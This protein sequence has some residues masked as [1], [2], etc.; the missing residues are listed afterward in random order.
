MIKIIGNTTAT[1]IVPPN[2]DSPYIPKKCNNIDYSTYVYSPC[3]QSWDSAGVIKTGTTIVKKS[4]TEFSI[5][6][7][8]FYG[9]PHMGET[10]VFYGGIGDAFK[11]VL[12]GYKGSE[13]TFET[14]SNIPEDTSRE[15]FAV[16]YSKFGVYDEE[17]KWAKTIKDDEVVTSTQLEFAFEQLIAQTSESDEN[18][19][20]SAKAYTDK[21][22]GEIETEAKTYTN[23]MIGDMTAL[24]HHD[25]F[26]DCDGLI[27][28]EDCVRVKKIS[29]ICVDAGTV[30]QS[31]SVGSGIILRLPEGIKAGASVVFDVESNTA[32]HDGTSF[33]DETILPALK[34][35]TAASF[36]YFNAGGRSIK[37]LNIEY[38]ISTK[39]YADTSIQQAILDS[40]EVGV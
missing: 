19:L 34:D 5:T 12:T 28:P 23:K 22:V 29:F 25:V 15:E 32:T 2:I 4:A 38:C 31:I 36:G 10:F 40:W 17:Y 11:C 6:A 18:T 8:D 16:W 39:T 26:Y 7:P 1:P 21:K 14:E 24:I 33:V 27:L 9:V 20:E 37:N 30:E 3:K 13:Y 35:G